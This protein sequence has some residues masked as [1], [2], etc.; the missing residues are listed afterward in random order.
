MPSVPALRLGGI[1][2]A[3]ATMAFGFIVV[4][5]LTR[6]E[7][8]TRGSLGMT[9]R[10]INLTGIRIDQEWKLYYVALAAVVLVMLGVLNLLQS[11]TGRAFI[12]IRDSISAQSMGI[13][14]ARYKTIAFALSAAITGLAGALYAQAPPSARS[15]SESLFRSNSR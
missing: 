5:V 11:P 13:H 15:S 2:L 6:W 12:A 8:V 14:L 4:E 7:S 9:V 10:S 3:I 1:Y